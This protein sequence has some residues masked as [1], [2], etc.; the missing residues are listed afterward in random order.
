MTN[1][2]DRMIG[3]DVLAAELRDAATS[4]RAVA[5]RL[6]EAADGAVSMFSDDPLDELPVGVRESMTHAWLFTGPPGS[7]RSVA[8]TAFAAALQCLD[9]DRVGCGE[10]RACTT[11][12]GGTHGDVRHIQPDGLSI[13]VG[14]IRH[15]VSLAAR[16]PTTGRWQIVVVEDA[17]R[18]TEHG[19]NALLKA[20]E[21]PPERT[22]FLL[23]APSVAPEDIAITLRSRCR[24]VALTAPASDQIAKVLIERDGIDPEPAHW[25]ASV[26]GGHVGRA[27]R[28]ATDPMSREQRE[29]ALSL[30][31]AATRDSTAFAAADRLVKTAIET[32]DAISAEVD[33]AETDEL[34]TALGAGGTGKGTARPPRGTAGVIKELEK[35]QRSRKT[36]LTRDVL[37]RALVDLAAL[38]RD[39]LSRSLG[40]QVT[41]M[42]PDKEHDVI[43]GMAGYAS[44]EK[45]L[46]CIEA[47]LECR[48]ALEKNVK[49]KFAVSAMVVR[50]G[51]QLASRR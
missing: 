12:M 35:R 7:G 18:L 29:Q 17:D 34:M 15:I 22:I 13:S 50:I 27:K 26:S 37:D 24:H 38:F 30:A 31:R 28:L 11:T 23:C 44:P 41:L 4:A 20:V 16:R 36:R 49:P 46:A 3:Q 47:V 33:A 40:A 25:A 5:A 19:A 43:A 14:Q 42:H 8:A 51:D 32:A 21:E 45:L 48:D 9:P 6:D 2:F 1:V 39:A 10:C